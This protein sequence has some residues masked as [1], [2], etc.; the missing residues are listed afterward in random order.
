[1]VVDSI[2]GQDWNLVALVDTGSAVSFVT[3]SVYLAYRKYF[4]REI[5]PTVRK[6][7][8]IKDLPLEV[9]GTVE[10][11]LTLS[12]LKQK[13]F[14]VTLFVIKDQAFSHDLILGRD[15][16]SSQNLTVMF[17]FREHESEE[18]NNRL[19]LFAE[20]PLFIDDNMLTKLEGQL[21]QT[22]IDFNFQTKAVN[23]RL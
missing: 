13:R 18:E 5:C 9:I 19:G 23:N 6:F 15:F 12:L 16:L 14:K 4:A 17:R 3:Y 10:V 1:V 2:Q 20:L 11:K 21:Q 7:V 8:N 22:E